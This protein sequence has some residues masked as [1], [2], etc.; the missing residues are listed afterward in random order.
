MFL[1]QPRNIPTEAALAS[2]HF[3]IGEAMVASADNL[4][5]HKVGEPSNLLPGRL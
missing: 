4:E 3:V 2:L 1:W 5:A